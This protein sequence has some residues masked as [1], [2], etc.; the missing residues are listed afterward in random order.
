LETLLSIALFDLRM[1]TE[2]TA[3]IPQ[4]ELVITPE[5]QAQAKP[6]VMTRARALRRAFEYSQAPLGSLAP[7]A[8]Q[9]S[10]C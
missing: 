1:G 10:P 8:A 2:M 7:A 5:H 4:S 3:R 9:C 6:Y